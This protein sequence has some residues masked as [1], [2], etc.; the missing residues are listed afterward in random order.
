MLKSNLISMLTA[1]SKEQISDLDY[2][3]FVFQ[4]LKKELYPTYLYSHGNCHNVSHLASMIL[5]QCG[6][7]HQKIWIFAPCRLDPTRK[8][9]IVFKI[10]NDIA[11]RKIIRWGYHVGILVE[12][13]NES[14]VVDL[15][16]DTD[17]PI[18]LADW[19]D[20]LNSSMHQIFVEPPQHYLY[21]ST[22][23][24]PRGK[25]IFNG[26][27]FEYDGL[28]RDDHWLPKGLAINQIA[29]EFLLNECHKP[30]ELSIDCQQLIKSIYTFDAFLGNHN[31]WHKISTDFMAK[32]P[33]LT[34]Q[35]Q[36]LYQEALDHWM[37]VFNYWD[38]K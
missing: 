35:Y 33:L 27:F 3:S 2:I 8:E 36:Y 28:C 17:K 29:Y 18:R 14:Y 25:E 26:T 5:T 10:K 23:H 19:N 20:Q 37:G 1:H 15:F 12:L 7:D 16:M 9:S 34:Q 6:I 38:V 4:Q 31:K 22:P 30:T 21:H 11:P 24:P 13:Q 32:H